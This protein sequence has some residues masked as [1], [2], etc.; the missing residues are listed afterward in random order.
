MK[1]FLKRSFC[2]SAHIGNGA[3]L[4]T[5]NQII[6]FFGSDTM[7]SVIIINK[8]HVMLIEAELVFTVILYI[9]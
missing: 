1:E 4:N 9:T 2:R 3:A 8:L 5:V 7:Y 6:D